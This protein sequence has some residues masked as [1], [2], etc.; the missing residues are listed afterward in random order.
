[1]SYWDTSALG[2]LYF[3][4]ADSAD[5][6]RKAA[7]E[8]VIVTAKLA[9]F[10]MLR[11]AFRKEVEGFIL[12]GTAETV[13]NQIHQDIV[14]GEIRIVQIDALGE[15]ALNTTMATCY[16]RTPPLLLR[17]LDAIHLT[18]AVSPAKRK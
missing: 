2:K 6:L 16:R 18:T 7:N 3:P 12:P 9:T 4:E 10:E 17:T 14:A 15:A 11:V 13:L 8:P 1:M 5:F